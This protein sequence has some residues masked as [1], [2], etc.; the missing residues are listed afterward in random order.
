MLALSPKRNLHKTLGHCISSP[1]YVLDGD[2]C[3]RV[4]KDWQEH[5]QQ[6]CLCQ[7][8]SGNNQNARQPRLS[9]TP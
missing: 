8:Q 2:T 5:P 9:G 4:P 3:T 1:G 7:S 6:H